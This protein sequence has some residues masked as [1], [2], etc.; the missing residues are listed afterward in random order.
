MALNRIELVIE[1]RRQRDRLAG[2]QDHSAASLHFAPHAIAC[3]A[4]RRLRKSAILGAIVGVLETE[5][6][7]AIP[8]WRL[9]A[10]RATCINTTAAGGNASLMTLGN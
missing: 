7:Q 10:E 3:Y 8:L 2:A 6:G 4:D 1:K 9:V 5:A